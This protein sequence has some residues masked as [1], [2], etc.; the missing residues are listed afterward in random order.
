MD[1]A[2]LAETFARLVPGIPLTVL[3]VS[4]S[5]ALGGAMALCL[6]WLGQRRARPA[7]MVYQGYTAFFRSTPMLVQI[8]LVY[9]G[10]GQFSREL[11]GL[12]LWWL[13][14]EPWFCAVLAMALNTAAYTA[15]IIRGGLLAVPKAQR[16]A[17]MALGLPPR[18]AFRVVIFPQA[19]RQALPAYGNEVILMLKGTSL[20]STITILEVTGIAK[21]IISETLQ[22]LEVFMVAGAIYL[23]L[24][25]AVTRGVA[26]GERKLAPEGVQAP[27]RT[28][29]AGVK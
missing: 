11:Q 13:F 3:L 12:G 1:V 6:S 16:E 28:M 4:A 7:R 23:A 10:S 8:F 9:Y 24:V 2:F 25:F 15:E 17:A 18:V 19:L 21:K 14:R 27:S 26:W 22:P 5:L 29:V 20:A